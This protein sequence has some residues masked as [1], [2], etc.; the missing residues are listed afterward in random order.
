MNLSVKSMIVK[1]IYMKN[2]GQIINEK[3]RIPFV[4]IINLTK[5]N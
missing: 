5:K 1:I 4:I 3:T 2:K